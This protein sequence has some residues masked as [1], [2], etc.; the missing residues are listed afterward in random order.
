MLPLFLC[1]FLTV[2]NANRSNINNN[3]YSALMK[4]DIPGK[5]WKKRLKNTRI[6]DIV[7]TFYAHKLFVTSS[8]V[9]RYR[10]IEL[11]K[12]K[13]RLHKHYKRSD[14]HNFYGKV[15]NI[16]TTIDLLDGTIDK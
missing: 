7:T 5:L 8:D 4:T 9:I 10:C 15:K 14:K 1:L 2:G 16:K 6:R 3:L 13:D 11:K 12:F